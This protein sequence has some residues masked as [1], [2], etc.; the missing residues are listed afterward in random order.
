MIQRLS[1]EICTTRLAS[2]LGDIL[3]ACESDA[4]IGLYFEGQKHQPSLP[5]P[6]PDDGPSP[7]ARSAAHWLQNYFAGTVSAP[8]PAPLLRLRGTAFQLAV[9][10]ALQTIPRGQTRTYA[11]IAQAIGAPRAVRAVGAAIGRNPVSIL[12]PC[13]RVVGR[14]GSLTGYAG[15]VARKEALLRLEGVALK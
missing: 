4:L 6:Q 8:A 2:P 1:A 15:G 10:Q 5:M 12:V 14:D 11:Q 9:W 3:L 13:H 7:L